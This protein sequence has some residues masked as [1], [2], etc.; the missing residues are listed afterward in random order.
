MQR[1]SGWRNVDLLRAIV[2]FFLVYVLL[3]FFWVAHSI[4]LVVILAAILGVTLSRGVDLLERRRVPRPVG[5]LLI[6][7]LVLAAIIG[8]GSLIAPHV[9]K[10]ANLLKE[11]LPAAA[12]QIQKKIPL[13]GTVQSSPGQASQPSP[14]AQEQKKGGQ[15]PAGEQ[16]AG[17]QQPRSQKPQSSRSGAG[18][19]AQ[20]QSQGGGSGGQAAQ[21]L[22][23]FLFPVV[24]NT[25]AA[26]TALVLILFLAAYFAVDPGIY[27]RGA[28][29]L[30]PPAK[31]DRAEKLAE[32]VGALLRQWMVARLVAMVVIGA[33]TGL[34][35]WAL[36]IPAAAA[37]GLIAGLLEFIPFAGPI[38]A[39]IPAV[40]MALVAS[41]TK[42]IYV[43]ILFVVIQQLEGNLLTPLLMKNRIDVPPAI[44]IIAVSA[45]GM[46]FGVVG[47]L[48]AEPL[49]GVAILLIRELYVHRL[50]KTA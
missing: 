36:G 4:L 31:R 17:N 22:L 28:L 23:K 45:L 2:L 12:A 26:I 29:R 16:P 46:V 18:G 27:K 32:E 7:T 13:L 47:M 15:Q 14:G 49:S 37:L 10:Q 25:L 40:A 41:P 44:T 30:V 43:V 50:E 21:P 6:L 19:A 42:A 8:A 5:L 48:V 3:R 24:S 1:E 33:V 35:L 9:S 20:S 38:I 34:A 39:A 11:R